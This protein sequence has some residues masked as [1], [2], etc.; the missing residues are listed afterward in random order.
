MGMTPRSYCAR[1]SNARLVTIPTS[2][3]SD[4]SFFTQ[5]RDFGE[6]VT[7]VGIVGPAQVVLPGVSAQLP[8]S[9]GAKILDPIIA[10]AELQFAIAAGILEGTGLP[11][12]AANPVAARVVG[13]VPPD[14]P[15]RMAAEE[16]RIAHLGGSYV[17]RVRRS[18]RRRPGIPSGRF[19]LR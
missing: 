12:A 2:P 4:V 13:Q 6:A 14:H 15:S 18:Y 7:T 9:Q 8:G 17:R 16:D 19:F 1:R 5:L 3:R 11:M 10:R